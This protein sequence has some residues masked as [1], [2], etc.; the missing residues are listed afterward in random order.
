MT[1][2]LSTVLRYIS[3]KKR[4]N[5]FHHAHNLGPYVLSSCD[6]EQ[7]GQPSQA[8]MHNWNLRTLEASVPQV[9]LK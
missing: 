4:K 2:K 3:S 1:L 5:T 8:Y 9:V 7:A 6:P